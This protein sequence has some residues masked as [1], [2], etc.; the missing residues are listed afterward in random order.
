VRLWSALVC[1]AVLAAGCSLPLPQGVRT[2]EGSA[3]EDDPGD[4]QVMPPGPGKGASA[5]EIVRGFL[6]AESSPEGGHAISRRFL[7]RGV[8]WF[9]DQVRVYD[10]ASLRLTSL[11]VGSVEVS[12][13]ELGRI[14]KAGRYTAIPRT[15]FTETYTLVQDVRGEWRISAPP[16]G[17]RLTPADRERSF[18]ARQIYFIRPSGSSFRV[19][20]DQVLLPTGGLSGKVEL[21]RLLDGP[22]D[23]LAGSVTTAFP[24]GTRLLKVDDR[25]A[26]SYDISLSREAE[27]ANEQQRQQLSAQLVWT[28]R[29]VDPGLRGVRILVGSTPLE[30]PG[31]GQV[32]RRDDWNAF[33]PDGISAGPAY[34]VSRGR[35]ATLVGVGVG[36]PAGVLAT[37]PV[38]D[39]A[40]TSGRDR[41]ALLQA[42]PA[43]VVVRIGDLPG[44]AF[45]VVLR[46]AGLHSPSWGA[47]ER[48]LW[49]LDRTGR[50]L[51]V[52]SDG[53]RRQVPVAGVPGPVSALEVSRDGT[54]AALVVGGRLYVARVQGDGAN[55][56]VLGLRLV[57]PD[58]TRV[59]AVA[60]RGP[61]TLVVLGALSQAFV[62]VVVSVDGSSLR[63]LPVAGL[64][65]RPEELAASS[66]GTIV[67]G[68]GHLYVLGTLGFRQ[69]PVGS[70][71]VYPG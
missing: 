42:D 36:R 22:S 66:L 12:F 24:Q 8:Q 15:P 65:A 6:G 13:T 49:L 26:G 5:E 21:E 25:G 51:V 44:R 60:W 3:I 11:S 32:Q 69:G 4:L 50:V 17:L 16:A 30:V 59:T 70:G 45:P 28:L 10:P 47:G 35:L 55:L 20:P 64:P 9:D 58:L 7:A 43:G 41:I 23:D 18:P 63:P 54:R 34:F 61:T 1:V 14:D 40:V 48:G 46:A 57:T 33:D 27:L 38:R 31:E 39:V 56:R 29:D 37:L 62:P 71:P 53:R 19:V 2:H 67:T 52:Q 68:A